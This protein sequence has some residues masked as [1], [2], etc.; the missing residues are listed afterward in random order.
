MVLNRKTVDKWERLNCTTVKFYLPSIWIP[1]SVAICSNRMQRVV[2]G[3]DLR[4]G[5]MYSLQ[6]LQK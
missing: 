4:A 5:R 2:T 6:Q 1:L 3:V